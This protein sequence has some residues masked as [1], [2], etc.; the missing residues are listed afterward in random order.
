M[1]SQ[2]MECNTGGSG[3]SL[4]LGCVMPCSKKRIHELAEFDLLLLEPFKLTT[5]LILTP[6]SSFIGPCRQFVSVH[7]KP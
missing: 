7:G 6:A 2:V 4:M 3:D 1:P 5:N